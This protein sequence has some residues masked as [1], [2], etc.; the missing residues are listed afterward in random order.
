MIR[1]KIKKM[2][3]NSLLE[4]LTLNPHFFEILVIIVRALNC[5]RIIQSDLQKMKFTW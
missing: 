5:I 3:K 4:L 1:A 2:R